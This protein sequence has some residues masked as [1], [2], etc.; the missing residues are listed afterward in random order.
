MSRTWARGSSEGT[1][2]AH[3]AAIYRKAGVSGR[4]ELLSQF[5]DELIEAPVKVA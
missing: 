2:K 3:S 5:V 4:H 1:V